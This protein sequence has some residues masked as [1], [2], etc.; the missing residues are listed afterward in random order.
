MG[1]NRTP[2]KQYKFDLKLLCQHCEERFD[3]KVFKMFCSSTCKGQF[4]AEQNRFIWTQEQEDY[5]VDLLGTV[6]TKELIAK[7]KRKF[8]LDIGHNKIRAK[9]KELAKKEQASLKDLVDNYSLRQWSSL[10][11]ATNRKTRKWIDM[12]LK[13]KLH[14]TYYSVSVSSMVAFAKDNPREF[15]DTNRDK[16]LWLFDDDV[17]WVDI[18]KKARP[19]RAPIRKVKC[20]D[21]GFIYRSCMEASKR[22]GLSRLDVAKSAKSNGVISIGKDYLRFIYAD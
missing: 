12:G 10:L 8:K 2:S 4:Y 16:L 1:S 20:I 15:A 19:L 21:T 14:G 18:I 13:H 7:V 6:P 22:T 9:I 11:G 5:I 17:H 3:D